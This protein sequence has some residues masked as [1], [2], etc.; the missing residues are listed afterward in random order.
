[1]VVQA[2]MRC[3][4]SF[5]EN[6]ISCIIETHSARK[7]LNAFAKLISERRNRDELV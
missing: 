2:G 6:M 4:Y 3:D 5:R 1:M 7:C